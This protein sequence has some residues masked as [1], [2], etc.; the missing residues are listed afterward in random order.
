MTAVNDRHVDAP[1]AGVLCGAQ[2][3]DH[4]TASLGALTVALRL[5][6]RREPADDALDL[7][8]LAAIGNKESVDVGQK[9]EPVRLYR[10][11]QQGAEFVVVTEC[12]FQFA[13][14]NA[15][16]LIHDGNGS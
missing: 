2:F 4:A 16:V 11:R 12:A 14:G 15:I 3:G 8:F 9:Q 10:C 7:G 1:F 5:E 13:N 6:L